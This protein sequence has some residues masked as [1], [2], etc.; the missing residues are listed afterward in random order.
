MKNGKTK[1][2]V[3]DARFWKAIDDSFPQEEVSKIEHAT[4]KPNPKGFDMKDSF[5]VK[6]EI[7]DGEVKDVHP[8]K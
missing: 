4:A 1:F 7:K 8:E 6:L 3:G 2:R 5:E